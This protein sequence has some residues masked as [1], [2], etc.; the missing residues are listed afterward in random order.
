MIYVYNLTE[1]IHI[2][3]RK[4]IKQAQLQVH[5]P[6]QMSYSNEIFVF[7]NVLHQ[8]SVHYINIAQVNQYSKW[9]SILFWDQVLY[10]LGKS[11]N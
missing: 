9:L 7:K 5:S 8:K 6:A 2:E 11:N 1:S 3:L 4:V 10:D